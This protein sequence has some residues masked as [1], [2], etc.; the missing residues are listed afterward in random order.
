MENNLTLNAEKIQFKQKQVSFYGHV[1]SENGISPD[2][3][4]IQALKH[5]EFP[6]DKETMRSFLGM[7]NYLNRYSALSAHLAAPL[8]SLTHQ[9]ADYK[10]EKTH[11]ENFQRLKM[12]ISK[13]EALPYFNTSAETTLQMDASKK[14]LGA[15]LIQNGKVVCYASRS[16][17][18]TEQNYQNLEREAL[19]TIWGMEKFHYF[20][21]GKEFTL[22]TDQK[23]LVSIYKKHM[24]DISPRVQRLIVRSFPYQPFTVV[25]KKG[26]DIPVADALSRVTPM[27]P[28]D[29]IK[30][31]II[32]VN[33]ITKLV[34]MS[35]FAQDNFSRKLDRIRKSTSQDDQLTRLSRYINTGFPCEKKNL[36]RDLQDYWNYRDTLSIENGLITCGSRI[37]VPHEMRAEMM[38]YIHEGH[39]GKERC[40]LR[41]RNTV[42]WPRISHDIQVLIE[43]CIICQEHGKSQP[44]VGITQELPPFPW[45]T[46]ATD[47]F[48]WKRMDFLIV[49]DVFSKYFLIRKLINSTSTAVCAEIATIVTELG[50]PHVIR[51]DN[52]PC[53]S[54]KE[55]QQMLQRYNITHHTSSPH[56][57]RSNG[58]VERMVGV[59]KK[60]MDKAGSEGKPWISGLYEY[61]VTPQSGSI[62]SPLQLLTQCIPREK[63]LPQLPSTLGAQEMYDTRQEILRRQPDS[64]ERSYI[65]LTPGMAVW[66]QH[67]QN[68]SWEPAIIASQ[69]SPNSYWIMQENGDDQPKLY[70][71]TRSMLKIRCTEVR[72][73]SLEY[74][75]PTEMNKAKFHSPYS[76][77]EERNHVQ[78]NSVD[79]IPR[80]LVIPTKSNT[81]APDSVFSEGKEENIADI[82]EEAPAEVPAPAPATAPTLE[83]VEE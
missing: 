7:I 21:Y 40:L 42:F 39:Q 37:I 33:M 61:R 31:P 47:I 59:A 3:K 9:A 20:L 6:P 50:L 53:Y 13:T 46:L 66:V 69:T 68:T 45:H 58:F 25:Y 65:E 1:W 57:P 55:F 49:P 63:D 34:L 62:A 54:S 41:A 72:K 80:D 30:L 12:E 19:G 48:Y 18:K 60:L 38:Q 11:M 76:L 29:N 67:K 70:R 14:G 24:V 52:G 82:A 35:T 16:L 8:S 4:K 81:S 51:S 43:R 23:P 73:P 27:D 78:H 17:T 71:R 75:Q 83:T 79:K 56:H 77:N 2:P 22:E 32:A 28:E 15:C 74:N 26:R 64:L 10:P 36:P 44:I 5:M